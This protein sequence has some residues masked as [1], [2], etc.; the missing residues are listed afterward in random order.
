MKTKYV[1][2][3]TVELSERLTKK[4]VRELVLD[5]L[6]YQPLKSTITKV[7]VRSVDED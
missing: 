6:Y 4:A 1:V 5:A 7:R 3:L 2:V